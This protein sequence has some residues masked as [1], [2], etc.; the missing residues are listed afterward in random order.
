MQRETGSASMPSGTP[1]SHRTVLAQ[2]ETDEQA[3]HRITAG[4]AERFDAQDIAVGLFDAGRGR[5]QVAIHFRGRIDEDA[6]RA[7]VSQA[8]GM[9]AAKAL[10]FARVEETDWVRQSLA[11]LAPVAAG[12]FIVHGVHDRARIPVN[13]IGIE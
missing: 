11:G 3:A 5:W 6:M 4:V 9:K 12:R 13:R 10:H 7:A 8:A 1:S 2:L